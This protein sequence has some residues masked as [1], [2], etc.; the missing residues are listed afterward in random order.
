MF[1]HDTVYGEKGKTILDERDDVEKFIASC[2]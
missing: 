1:T 2:N